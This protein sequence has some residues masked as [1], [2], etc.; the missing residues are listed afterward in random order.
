MD[1]KQTISKRIIPA[2][3]VI[4]GILFIGSGL[5]VWRNAVDDPSDEQSNAGA[6]VHYHAAFQIYIDSVLQDYSGMQFMNIEPC[7][8]EEGEESDE[9]HDLSDVAERVHLH[10]NVGTVAHV[11]DSGVTWRNLFESL[12]IAELLSRPVFGYTDGAEKIGLL[13]DVMDPNATV[14]FGIGN[15]VPPLQYQ[16]DLTQHI[17]KAELLLESCGL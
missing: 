10:N 16:I 11:H 8:D 13:D 2:L 14:V 3:L 1:P 17:V 7:N 4:V 12:G 5:Y 9:E 6:D 15:Q